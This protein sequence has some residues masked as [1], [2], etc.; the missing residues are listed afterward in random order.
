MDVKNCNKQQIISDLYVYVQQYEIMRQNFFSSLH[1]S[2]GH[3]YE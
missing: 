2:R 3:V 1:L